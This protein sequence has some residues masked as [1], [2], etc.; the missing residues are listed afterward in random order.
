[1]IWL[2]LAYLFHTMGELCLSPVGLSYVSKLSPKHLVGLIFGVWFFSSA[3]ALKLGGMIGG[4]I[5][6]ISSEYSISTFFMIFFVTSLVAGFILLLISP[7][8]KRMMHGI[9]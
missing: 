2:I 3:V 1:M 8:L 6:H 7:W 4:L 5:D 9:H